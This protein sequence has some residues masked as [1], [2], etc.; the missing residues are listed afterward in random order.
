MKP[1]SDPWLERLLA[2]WLLVWG[3]FG[4]LPLIRS[5]FDGETYEWGTTWFGLQVGGAGVTASLA[6]L[7]VKVVAVVATLYCLLR[8]SG[9]WNWALPLLWTALLTADGL[10]GI[11]ANPEGFWFHG[12]T[13]GIHLNLGY[14]IPGFNALFFLVALL[15]GWRSRSATPERLPLD[16]VNLRWL[17]GLLVLLPIQFALLRSGT[18]HG[19]TDQVGVLLTIAQWF[20]LG[21][22]LRRTSGARIAAHAMA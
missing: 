4:W 12:D 7:A 16:I 22:A 11:V 21:A 19:I 3:L 13:L 5:V 10:Y 20:L 8:R 9:P 18:P 17:T 1:S 15:H 6:L 2:F 14:V